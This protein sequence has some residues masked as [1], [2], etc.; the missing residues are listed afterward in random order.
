MAAGGPC[1]STAGGT[2]GTGVGA[3]AMIGLDGTGVGTGLTWVDGLGLAA[4]GDTCAVGAGVLSGPG[5]E[6]GALATGP[7]GADG[8]MSG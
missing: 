5:L 8:A 6:V 7:G 2:T 1:G 3:T 4:G